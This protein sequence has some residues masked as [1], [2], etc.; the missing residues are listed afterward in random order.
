[1]PCF[2]LFLFHTLYSKMEPNLCLYCLNGRHF[3]KENK[4]TLECK[5]SLNYRNEVGNLKDFDKIKIFF[6]DMNNYFNCLTTFLN[7]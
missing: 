3:E 2:T 1:M 4:I 6:G 7:D 5:V